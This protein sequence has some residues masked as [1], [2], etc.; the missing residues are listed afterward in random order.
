MHCDG[1]LVGAMMPT[2]TAVTGQQDLQNKHVPRPIVQK[3]KIVHIYGFGPLS[4]SDTHQPKEYEVL[5]VDRSQ[6]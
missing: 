3:R 6:H 5:L 2:C 1:L 4:L